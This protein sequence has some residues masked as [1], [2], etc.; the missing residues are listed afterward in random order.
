MKEL[1]EKARVKF[2]SPI[3]LL[4]LEVQCIKVRGLKSYP[5]MIKEYDETA[6]VNFFITEAK[7]LEEEIISE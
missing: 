7:K 2:D 1:I 4:N 6:L 3:D 5:R